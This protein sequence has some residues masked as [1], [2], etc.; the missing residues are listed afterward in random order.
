MDDLI[1]A[2]H[3]KI[4]EL[5][6]QAQELDKTLELHSENEAPPK[7]T[8][9]R[10]GNLLHNICDA[11]TKTAMQLRD[12]KS[13][14]Q[15]LVRRLDGIPMVGPASLLERFL[16]EHKQ[17]FINKLHVPP[18]TVTKLIDYLKREAEEGDAR[19]TDQHT[20]DP[21]IVIETLES[22]RDVVCDLSRMARDLEIIWSP[23]LI[24]PV[25][26][27][28]IGTCLVVSDIT[29]A[30]LAPDF[31]GFV[32]FKAVK[33]TMAGVRLVTASVSAIKER[34]SGWRFKVN[35]HYL[36]NK[37]PPKPKR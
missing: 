36:N 2:L 22:F 11:L 18:A 34:L 4:T 24:K 20:L 28:V 23:D 30:I 14:L 29:G 17:F 19:L 37:R 6:Q 1:Q 35:Q 27:G 7:E 25:V 15:E 16:E 10:I 5:L 33:S 32:L 12:P 13:P 21:N 31:T 26:K 3:E 8:V 9:E